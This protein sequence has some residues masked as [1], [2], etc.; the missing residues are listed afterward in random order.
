MPIAIFGRWPEVRLLFALYPLL[1]VL[2]LAYLE[3]L[4]EDES[5]GT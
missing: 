2:G 3:P 4:L 1:L 5:G